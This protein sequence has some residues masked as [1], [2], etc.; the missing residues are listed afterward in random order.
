MKQDWL[1]WFAVV[2]AIVIGLAVAI[3]QSVAWLRIAFGHCP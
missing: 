1:L 2:L 3:T